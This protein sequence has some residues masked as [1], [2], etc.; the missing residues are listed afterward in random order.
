MKLQL[1]KEDQ[2]TWIPPPLISYMADSNLVKTLMEK[3]DSLKVD[4][5]TQPGDRDNETVEI[6]VPLFHMGSP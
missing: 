5:K 2:K 6:Y 3:L 4:I 1:P